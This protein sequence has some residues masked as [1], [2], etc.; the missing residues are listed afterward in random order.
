MKPRLYQLYRFYIVLGFA[1]A[2]SDMYMDW[3]VVVAVEHEPESK[4][5]EQCWHGKLR[6][7]VSKLLTLIFQL[8]VNLPFCGLDVFNLKLHVVALE[9][10]VLNG[11]G[12]VERAFGLDVAS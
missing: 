5:D 7:I 1:S 3:Q 2:L 4:E 6:T 11:V 12:Y 10:I 8:L 9:N